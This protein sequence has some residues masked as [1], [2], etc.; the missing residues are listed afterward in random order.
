MRRR[1][2]DEVVEI[3]GR[4]DAV[5]VGT[6]VFTELD[7]LRG[8]DPGRVEPF[9]QVLTRDEY[10][11]TL[12]HNGWSGSFPEIARRCSADGEWFFSV[13]WNIHA[14]GMTTQAVDG[15]VTASFESVFP[16][17]PR[18]RGGDRRPAWAIGPEVESAVTWQVCMAH[19]E[20]QTGVEV[21]ERWLHEPHPT[22]RVLEPHWLY[23]DVDG[24]DRI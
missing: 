7:R 3:F 1:D 8:P 15:V 11:V 12:E 21:E 24:A 14:A 6:A 5:A 9:L 10:T 20:R 19:L 13:C 17:E 23:R 16:V 18:P 4:G 22:Y 2:H